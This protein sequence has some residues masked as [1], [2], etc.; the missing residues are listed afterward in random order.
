MEAFETLSKRQSIRRFE[1]M[2]MP[3]EDV[4]KI[5]EAGFMAPSAMNRRPYEFLA[6]RDN[7]FWAGWKKE[8]STC[9]IIA[10]CALTVLVIGDS[11]KQPSVE[12]LVSDAA[13]VSE[14]MLLG[15]TA[16]GYAS[17]WCGIKWESE[18]YLS[19]IKHFKLPDGYLPIALLGF[20]KG[21]EK[22]TQVERFD[23]KKVHWERF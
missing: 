9:L 6:I 10:D 15:A 17:L 22:K 4:R 5:L 18:F 11:N 1:R 16:L 14:N 3:K 19:L 13:V 12:F 21:A 7:A 2:E 23:E 20:G 8:K